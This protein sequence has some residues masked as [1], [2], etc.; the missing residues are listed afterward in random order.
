MRRVSRILVD[1]RRCRRVLLLS[2]A[3]SSTVSQRFD[4]ASVSCLLWQTCRSDIQTARVL[5]ARILSRVSSLDVPTNY[6]VISQMR[7]SKRQIRILASLIPWRETTILAQA[8][9]SHRRCCALRELALCVL[10]SRLAM[11][12]PAESSVELHRSL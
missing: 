2:A 6:H 9:T 8:R 11:P 7:F 4:L 1:E 12:S 3:R 10:L 5:R